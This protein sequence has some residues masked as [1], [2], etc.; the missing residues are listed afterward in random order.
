MDKHLRTITQFLAMLVALFGLMGFARTAGAQPT[1]PVAPVEVVTAFIDAF[2]RGDIDTMRPLVDPGVRFVFEDPTS[3]TDE[4]FDQFVAE[5]REMAV[6]NSITQTAPDTVTASITISGADVPPLPVPVVL[7][8]TW[9]VTNGKITREVSRF[10]PET[11]A[12]FS[13]AGPLPGG[14]PGMPQT[15]QGES[16]FTLALSMLAFGLICLMVGVRLR[17]GFALD[18]K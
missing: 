15:G 16:V 2:N 18:G 4:G 14:Q 5:P 13:G 10:S 6:V 9:T 3:P 8:T 11:L 12:Y 17:R 7:D 1:E